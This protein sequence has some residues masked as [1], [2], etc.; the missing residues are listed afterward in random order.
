MKNPDKEKVIKYIESDEDKEN[1]QIEIVK[2]SDY[3]YL[4]RR[5]LCNRVDHISKFACSRVIKNKIK[6]VVLTAIKKIL[7]VMGISKIQQ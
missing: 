2:L 5:Y 7:T 6:E 3:I 1:F 4:E